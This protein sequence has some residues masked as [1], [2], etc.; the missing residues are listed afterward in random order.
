MHL[1]RSALLSVLFLPL[2]AQAQVYKCRLP[3]GRI[4]YAN[5][6]CDSS[7]TLAVR[8]EERISEAERL[9]AEKELARAKAFIDRR[10]A[11]QR[12][13][14]AAQLERLKVEAAQ[15]RASRPATLGRN[16]SSPEECLRDLDQMVLEAG[17]RNALENEC[18]RIVRS[19][20]STGTTVYVPYPVAVPIVTHPPHPPLAPQPVRP[21]PQ[22]PVTPPTRNVLRPPN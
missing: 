19:G 21:A 12:A 1:L 16:Y 7:T 17:Q 6:P 8:P 14:D 11:Q 2:L 15:Q 4:E 10:E 22:Q 9:A 5:R 20:S 3:D 13:D 18:R